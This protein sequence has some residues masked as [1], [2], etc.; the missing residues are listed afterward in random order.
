MG[1]LILELLD[2]HLRMASKAQLPVENDAG[3]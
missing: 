1:Q 2:H 3:S